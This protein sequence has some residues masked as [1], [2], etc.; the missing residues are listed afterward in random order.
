MSRPDDAGGVRSSG[1]R[2]AARTIAGVGIDIVDV[3]E[4][5]EAI[6]ALGRRY[7]ERVYAP[8]E[9]AS[10]AGTARRST[11]RS[12]APCFAAKEAALKAMGRDDE[13]IDWRS[14]VV[15]RIGPERIAIR[16]EGAGA[17]LA[18]ARCIDRV[19][20]SVEADRERAIAVVIAFAPAAASPPHRAAPLSRGS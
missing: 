4:I 10:W 11:A 20:G 9:L 15:D 17:R 7:L 3:V 13:P 2:V 5:E 18:A 16:L 14:V 6:T 1:G 8:D 12:L 19:V